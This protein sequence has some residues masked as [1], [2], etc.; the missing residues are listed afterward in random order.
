MFRIGFKTTGAAAGVILSGS[1]VGPSSTS[2]YQLCRVRRP[3]E[4][5]I[6]EEGIQTQRPGEELRRSSSL[7]S[8]ALETG[9]KNFPCGQLKIFQEV[10][11]MCRE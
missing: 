10:K 4:R 8:L 7:S 11:E 1:L 6:P 3:E 2:R 9:A 5:R